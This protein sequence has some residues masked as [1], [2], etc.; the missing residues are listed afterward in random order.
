MCK[1]EFLSLHG[2]HYFTFDMGKVLKG[3]PYSTEEC[4]LF[5]ELDS[6]N[7]ALEAGVLNQVQMCLVSS[8]KFHDGQTLS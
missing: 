6:N 4:H 8:E 1:N 7:R 2:V 3:K 5:L